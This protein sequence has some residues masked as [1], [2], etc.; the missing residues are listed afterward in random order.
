MGLGMLL[1]AAS[2]W[3]VQLVIKDLKLADKRLNLKIK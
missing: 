1:G 3:V 2:L